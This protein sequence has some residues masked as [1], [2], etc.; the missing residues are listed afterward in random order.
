MKKSGNNVMEQVAP[1]YQVQQDFTPYYVQL[2][3]A[4]GMPPRLAGL[5]QKIE[6]ELSLHSQIILKLLFF[7]G[8]RI[9]E[10]L[11][12]RWRDCVSESVFLVHGLKRSSSYSIFLPNF[13][14]KAE[15]NQR[16]PD[17]L[18][19]TGANYKKIYNFMKDNGLYVELPGR[20]TKKVTHSPR[21]TMANSAIAISGDS[22]ASDLLHHKSKSTIN[23]YKKEV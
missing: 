14:P 8:S 4:L 18:I 2:N 7:Y 12:I 1:Q 3:T 5:R 15:Q 19:F 17:L 23:Y 16:K 21:V 20:R 22:V 6:R 9:T 11:S 10:L 13:V